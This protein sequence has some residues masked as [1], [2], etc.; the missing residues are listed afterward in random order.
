MNEDAG[1]PDDPGRRPGPRALF[2]ERHSYRRRRLTDMARLLPVFG[3]ALFLV[4]LLWPGAGDGGDG[5]PTSLAILYIFGVWAGLIGLA[6]LFGL[7][8]RLL[9]KGDGADQAAPD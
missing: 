7:G 8:A 5:V 2:L 1:D 3:S 4:P 6:A 9:A